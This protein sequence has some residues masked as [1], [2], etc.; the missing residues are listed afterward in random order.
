MALRAEVVSE[1]DIDAPRALVW[2]VMVDLAA[3][4]QWN[5]FTV[6]VGSSLR[7]GDAVD[8]Q[9]ALVQGKA[10]QHQREY[11]RARVEEA[12]LCWGATF[13]VAAALKAERCQTLDDLPAG[14]TRYRTVDTLSGLLVPLV[15]RLHG[16]NMQ[17]GFDGVARGLKKEAEKRHAAASA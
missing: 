15:M 10:P 6:H 4:G 3:Y 9:V 11:V 8:M 7:V 17:R 5:P 12:R 16:D 2:S 1:I 13:G 14:G